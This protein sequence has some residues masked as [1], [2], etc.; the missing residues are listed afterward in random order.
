MRYLKAPL[1]ELIDYFERLSN[2]P[3]LVD[4]LRKFAKKR[5]RLAHGY[6]GDPKHDCRCTPTQIQR[7]RARISV[8]LL[9]RIDLHVEAPALS[10]TELRSTKSGENSG[11]VGARIAVARTRQ[12]VRFA[13]TRV[14]SNARMSHAQIRQHST[15]DLALG[16]LLQHAMEQLHLSAR[17]YDRILKVAR[18]IADLAGADKIASPHLLEAIQ[19]RSLDRNLFY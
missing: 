3:A 9:D 16:D 15:L 17:A 6:L 12:H 4:S 7:Y 10:L 11:D 14:T 19:Y 5:N 8:P 2:A 18:T 1:G 13:G